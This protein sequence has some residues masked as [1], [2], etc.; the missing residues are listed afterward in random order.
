LSA[1]AV[2]RF[3]PWSRRGLVAELRDSSRAAAGPLPF[4]G[5]IK[6]DMTLSGGVGSATTSAPIAGPGDVVGVDLGAIVRTTPRANASNVEPNFL[7]AIDFD[8]ADFPW[9]LTPSA[10]NGT[11]QLRP[12]LAL[13]VVEDRPGVTISVPAGAPLPQLHIDSGAT[14]ELPDLGGSWA[15]AHAQLLVEQGSGAE[16]APVDLVSD[17]DQHVSRLL[18]PRRLRPDTRW[19]ACLVPAFDAGVARGLGRV[20]S[21]GAIGPAWTD[22][23]SI[24]LPLYFH[25]SFG[26]GPEGDF[27]SL[28]RR[29]RPFVIDL[30]DGAPTVGTV[31]MH[32]GAAG[33]PV[34]LPDGHAKR[35]VQMDGALRDVEQED[36]KL[37]DVPTELRKPLGA[38]LDEI[39]DPSGTDPDD[40]AVGPPLYGSWPANR[41]AV[42]GLDRG[43]FAELNLDPR[44]RVAAGLGAEIVRA[45]Q[46][47]LMTACWQQVGGVVRA[48]SLLSRAR[49]SIEASTRL[50]GRSVAVLPQ[51]RLLAFAGPLTDRTPFVEATVAAAIARTSLPDTVVDPAIRRLTAPTSRFVRKVAQRTTGD[52]VGLGARLVAKLAAGSA[53]VDPTSFVPAGVSPPAGREPRPL[54][55]G[56]LDLSPIGLPVVRPAAELAALTQGIAAVRAQSVPSATERLRLRADLRSTGL[57]TRRHV[58]PLQQFVALG[59]ETGRLRTDGIVEFRAAAAATQPPPAAFVLGREAGGSLRV[60][61]VDLSGRGDIVLRTAPTEPNVVLGRFEGDGGAGRSALTRLPVDTLR[62]GDTPIV[63]RPG[64]VASEFVVTPRPAGPGGGTF[65]G[66]TVTVLPPSRDAVVLTRFETAVSRLAEISSVADA[67]PAAAVVPFALAQAA[68]VLK[69]RCAPANAHVPRLGTMVRFGDISLADL[70]GGSR[71]R[72]LAVSPLADRI[73]AYP[74]LP[75]PAYRMLARYDRDRLLPGVDSIPPDSVTLLETNPRFVVGFMAGVNHELNRELLW[76]RYP[77]DQRGTPMRRFWDRV[78]GETDIPPLHLWRPLTLTLAAQAGGESNLVLL[79]RGELLRRYPNTVVLAIAASGPDTPS[80]R[81]EDVERHIFSGYLEPDIAFFGFDLQDDDLTTGNGWFFALQEQVTEPRFALDETV[82]PRRGGRPTAWRA[83]AWPDTPVAP[84]DNFVIAA[85]RGVATAN[86]LAP[87]PTNGAATADALFQNP[88]QVLVHAR[89]LTRPR[90]T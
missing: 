30:E 40:G 18:C 13:A 69:A 89:H 28:A 68:N 64:P 72:G 58:N 70:R 61:A 85:L 81:D 43:W 12:W 90:Q 87:L 59:G 36:G 17:P 5:L 3:L 51:A 20:P 56:R 83:V 48:N 19:H 74:E 52:V 22:Q 49:L 44:A 14:D 26:T 24:V 79:V 73:M 15:W 37:T 34:D 9:L 66:P 80:T 86:Q 46:E 45:E 4:R 55:G 7:A 62:P 2:Y 88:V 32:I 47:D 41:F 42:D 53:E 25:W 11:G 33:G 27:E 31:K 23:D 39:A 76:R 57:I 38:L 78:D 6:L 65:E 60:G 67:R 75:E 71:V 29:L 21:P 10:A 50:H 1:P 54:P 82:D 16:A 8:D 84:G 35:I 77:T 63:I